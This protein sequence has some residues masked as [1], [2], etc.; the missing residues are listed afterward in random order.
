MYIFQ[1][2]FVSQFPKETLIPKK[3]TPNIEVCPESLAAM[4]EYLTIILRARVGY[5]MIDSKR[6]A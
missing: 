6:G 5:E 3:T 1:V 4:L 2:S